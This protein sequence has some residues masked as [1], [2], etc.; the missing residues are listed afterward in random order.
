[1]S[2]H[3]DAL[4]RANRF[5]LA[6]IDLK[7]EIKNG[8]RYASEVLRG[9]IPD[10]LENFKLEDLLRAVPRLS[11]RAIGSMCEAA[12]CSPSRTLGQLTFRQRSVIARLLGAWEFRA[13]QRAGRRARPHV[14]SVAGIGRAA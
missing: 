4:E 8:E 2:Q 7:W 5:R 9:E 12:E 14:S 1:M 3:M 11:Y 6:R 10:W 13:R